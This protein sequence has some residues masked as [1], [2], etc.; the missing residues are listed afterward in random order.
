MV[1]RTARLTID[2]LKGDH[3]KIKTAAMAM[4]ISMKDFIILSVAAYLHRKPNK[5]TEKALQQVKTGKGIRKFESLG[6]MLKDLKS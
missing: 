3:K 2:L 6:E 5:V 4:D 1:T